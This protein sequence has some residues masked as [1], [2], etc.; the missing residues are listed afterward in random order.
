MDVKEEESQILRGPF[1]GGGDHTHL[2]VTLLIPTLNERDGLEAILPQ[3]DPRWAEDIL[4]VDGGYTDGSLEV[5]RRWGHGRLLIQKLPGLF[6]AYREV[7]PAISSDIVV[8]FSPD[9]N[10]LAEAI[11]ALIEKVREGYDMVIAS[12]YLPGAGSQDDDP[13]TAFGNWMFTHA[14]NLIFG[15]RYT[16]SLVILRAYR[17]KLIPALEMETRAWDLEPQLAIRCAV[18]GKRVAEIPA[19][20]PRRIGGKRK[21]SVLLNGWAIVVLIAREWVRMRRLKRAARSSAPA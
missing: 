8:T 9:G 13:V 2:S 19:K 17:R 21:L 11:P 18:H 14:I 1:A 5:I 7:L 16:D 4:F 10:S 12:R 6:N 15:G 20:E 3:I